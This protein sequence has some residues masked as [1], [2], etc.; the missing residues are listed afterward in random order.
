MTLAEWRKAYIERLSGLYPARE[1][2]ALFF[3]ALQHA[4]GID[5]LHYTLQSAHELSQEQAERVEFVCRALQQGKPLQYITGEQ[6]FYSRRFAVDGRVLIPRGE[7]E[8]L[9]A[10]VL[11]ENTF[12]SCRVLDIGTGSGAIAVTLAAE[13]RGWQVE[14]WDISPDALDVA[15][16]NAGSL[17]AQVSFRQADILDES[18]WPQS[19][20]YDIVVSNPPY[21]LECERTSMHV[22][23][24]HHEPAGALFVPDDDPLL[25]YRAI[26]RFARRNLVPGGRLYFEINRAFG[27]G[28]AQL[29]EEE[30]YSAVKVLQDINGC[31]R[32][33]RAQ[34]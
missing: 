2:E 22:N 32:M 34:V 25:F 23:V 18:T 8:E 14:G 15:R 13:R 27:G 10:L 29:L 20:P 33:V 26:A 4:L 28:T 6:V 16:A 21:V 5:R 7:T 9:V 1:A 31:D 11:A 12:P 30:G 3:H 17:G 19:A 24:L